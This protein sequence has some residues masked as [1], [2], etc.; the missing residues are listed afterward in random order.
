MVIPGHGKFQ[1]W[2]GPDTFQFMDSTDRS[3]SKEF[4]ADQWHVLAPVFRHAVNHCN[5]VLPLVPPRL[6]SFELCLAAVKRN[7]GALAHV[8]SE[9]LHSSEL[10][11]AAVT[12]NGKALEYVPLGLKTARLCE[13]AVRNTHRALEYVPQECLTERLRRLSFVQHYSS[14]GLR[15]IPY[16]H[17]T[18]SLCLVAVRAFPRSLRFVPKQHLTSDLCLAALQ[19]AT[20]VHDLIPAEFLTADFCLKAVKINGRALDLVPP[21]LRS[22]EIC[23]AAVRQNGEALGLLPTEQR[24][25]ELCFA[26]LQQTLDARHFVPPHF[27]ANLLKR[28]P[29]NPPPSALFQSQ[30]ETLS[31]I[32]QAL[33]TY[34]ETQSLFLAP[35][36]CAA[37]ILT[38]F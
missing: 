11:L 21:H 8:P 17:R 2:L 15:Q 26:A 16:K 25:Q 33:P 10:L 23:Y 36:P 24:T 34:E 18:R 28:L 22:D 27:L 12:S 7:G 38:H 4:V 9:F 35:E 20:W 29:P 14:I 6:R 3:V 37:P 13:I 19:G 5:D 30:L 1:M 32:F 31:G